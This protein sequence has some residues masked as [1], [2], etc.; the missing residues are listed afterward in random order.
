MAEKVALFD[1]KS[2]VE[3]WES[4]ARD[5][6][7][8][9][10]KIKKEREKEVLCARFGI[11]EKPKTLQAIGD[12]YNITRE[13][14]RQIINNSLAKIISYCTSVEAKAAITI[15]ESYVKDNGGYASTEEISLDLSNNEETEKNALLFV[16]NLSKNLENVKTANDIREGFRIKSLKLSKLKEVTKKGINTLK[17][18]EKTLGSKEIAEKIGESEE[19][20]MAAL[21]SSNKT[22][23]TEDGK[24]GLVSWPHVN[25]RSIRDKSRYVMVR[26]GKPLHY[27]KLADK[28][29]EMGTKKVT[30]QSVHNELIKNT[31]FVLVG[32]GIYA[33]SDWGYTPGIV[34]EVIVEVL[35]EAGEPLHKKII[36]EEVLKRRIVKPSTVVLNL[37]KP[38]F[39]KV[40]KAVYTLN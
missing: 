25:P 2:G 15:I 24:W 17:E 8:N 26:H 30:K 12:K 34:E 28:I 22:M 38:R 6:I 11:G 27:E 39:K 23:K 3:N 32:R 20:V 14:V 37:Q 16:A 7:E 31:D 5:A 29:S 10:S 1:V 36:V 21:S 18:T 33:L 13:R 40:G 4:I 35:T 19:T 9:C